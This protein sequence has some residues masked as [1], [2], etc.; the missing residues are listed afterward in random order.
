MLFWLV[1]QVLGNVET[2]F[3]DIWGVKKT[4]PIERKIADYLSVMVF[5]PILFIISS[6]AMVFL[7]TQVEL[8]ISKIAILGFLSPVLFLMVK[9]LPYILIWILF[10]FIYV[11]MPNTHVNISSGIFGGIIAG[12]IYV[13]TQWA[14]ITFQIGV[15]R[16]NA[17]Y[18]SFAALPLFLGWL[19]ISW[20]IVLFGAEISFA[21]Q[22]V[23]TYEFEPDCLRASPY[24]KS[25]LSLY[26]M[27][28]IV[29]SLMSPESPKTPCTSQRIS[30]E[31]DIPIRL[32]RDILY[33]LVECGLLTRTTEDE[34][35]GRGAWYHPAYAPEFYTTRSV[36]AKIEHYG[37]EDIPV[38]KTPELEKLRGLLEGFWG[39]VS[40]PLSPGLL[41]DV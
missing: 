13:I 32:V 26:I 9:L 16:Y 8:I 11:F 36:L 25:L 35:K 28:F 22:N 24:F 31:L 18:G 40:S 33:T 6:G 7:T 3:N 10:S 39:S 12:T 4:R 17:I 27:H 21:N 1:I 29:K 34:D 30:H 5:A 14:Y 15:A 41:K 19:Q 2:S 20:L 23:D 38:T 37:S